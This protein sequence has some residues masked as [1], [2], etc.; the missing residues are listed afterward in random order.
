MNNSE[1]SPWKITIAKNPAFDQSSRNS[2]P[3][4]MQF[5]RCLILLSTFWSVSSNDFTVVEYDYS[6]VLVY[7]IPAPNEKK[8]KDWMSY[9]RYPFMCFGLYC[10]YN[11][12]I[13]E[14][15]ECIHYNDIFEHFYLFYDVS[16]LYFKS[17]YRNL[18][19]RTKLQIYYDE[20]KSGKFQLLIDQQFSSSYFFTYVSYVM[21]FFELA[22]EQ[23]DSIP[24][25]VRKEEVNGTQLFLIDYHCSLQD[26]VNKFAELFSEDSGFHYHYTILSVV[27]LIIIILCYLLSGD[28]RKPLI[29]KC[30]L[31]YSCST[32]YI[33]GRT[34]VSYFDFDNKVFREINKIVY[35]VAE[36]W[37][38]V[39]CFETFLVLR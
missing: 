12:V 21:N 2:Q 23:D 31:I 14:F 28:L 8:F 36:L 25:L 39:I 33:F 19:H 27:L 37:L 20:L 10:N 9:C 1:K 38:N 29:G 30:I 4:K 22:R 6:E 32:L 18:S 13:S 35:F 5:P 17:S 34:M 7:K 15:G 3:S 11:E 24:F 26:A 16:Y